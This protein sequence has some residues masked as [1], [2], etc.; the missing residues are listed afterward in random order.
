M[1]KYAEDT[2][3]N[4]YAFLKANCKDVLNIPDHNSSTVLPVD[5]LTRRECRATYNFYKVYY[6]KLFNTVWDLFIYT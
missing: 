4:L 2:N 6:W 5:I 3:P 1:L